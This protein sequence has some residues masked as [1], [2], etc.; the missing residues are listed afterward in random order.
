M[1][2]IFNRLREPSTWSGLAAVAVSLGL[3]VPPGTI[4]AV[5]QIG[6]GLFGLAGIFLPERLK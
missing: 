6:V 2:F 4:E 1:S 5:T 3:G